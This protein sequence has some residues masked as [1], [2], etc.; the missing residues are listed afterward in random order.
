VASAAFDALPVQARAAVYRQVASLLVG[1]GTERLDWPQNERLAT[2]RLLL[3]VRNDV[4]DD[5]RQLAP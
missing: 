3:S 5:L 1:E 2:W 4:P